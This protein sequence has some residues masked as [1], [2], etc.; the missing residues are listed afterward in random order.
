MNP[1][2]ILP[3]L[4][5]AFSLSIPI[6]EA[7]VPTPPDGTYEYAPQRST[8]GIGRFYMGREISGVMGHQAA[9]WLE[10]PQRTH[11]EMPDEV[12]ANLNLKPTDVVADIGAGSGYFSFRMA[13]LLPQGRVLAVDIQPEMLTLIENRKRSDG[14]NN[15]DT[16]LGDINDTRLPANSVDL[17]LL[18]DA[19]HEFSHP[20]EMMQ[21]MVSAM[22]SGG[23]IVLLEYRAED[24]TVPIRPLHKMTQDQVKKEMGVFG[25]QFVETLDFLPWQHMMVFSKP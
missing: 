1:Y 8:G 4:L 18:V 10:R 3:C 13:K 24:R 11:E 5:L 15:V 20:W 2:R 14:V 12:V 17:I 9:D 23:R 19:Y 7:Q 21:S 6:A 22:K 16:I 25:L